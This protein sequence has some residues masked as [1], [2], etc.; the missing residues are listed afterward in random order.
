MVMPK[1]SRPGSSR[2][3]VLVFGVVVLILV[4]VGVALAASAFADDTPGEDSAE[5]GFLRDMQTH[6]LQ[7]VEM[8]MIIRDRSDDDQF[9]AMA[10]DIAFSQTSQIGTMQ[11]FLLIWDL[12]PTGEQDPMEW[13]G[14]STTGLMPGMATEEQIEQLKTVPVEEAETLFL[15]LMNRHHIAGVDMAEEIIDRSDED[16]IIEM[17]ESMVR[18]QS[19]EIEIMNMF[20]AERGIEPVTMVDAEVLTA[21]GATPGAEPTEEHSG[22]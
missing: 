11:G 3:K 20:L 9:D 5:A 18:V 16:D 13:M 14:H 15:Q 10:T 2:A 7:A 19:A 1:L 4:L 12:N 8:A 21:S 6:H 17:A 22:H